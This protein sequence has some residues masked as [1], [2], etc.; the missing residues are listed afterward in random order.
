MDVSCEA[1]TIEKKQ[2]LLLPIKSLADEIDQ[3]SGEKAGTV[4]RPLFLSTI[5]D[6]DGRHVAVTDPILQIQFFVASLSS[7]LQ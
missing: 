5:D 7:V 4:S 6:F 1:T 2:N 3:S